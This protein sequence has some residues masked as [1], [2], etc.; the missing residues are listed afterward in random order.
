MAADAFATKTADVY[1][2]FIE[3]LNRQDLDA[4]ARQ[5]PTTCRLFLVRGRFPS[6]E[7]IDQAKDHVQRV[8]D[9]GPS[10]SMISKSCRW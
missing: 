8:W 1:R 2:A 3:A 9:A 5:Q 7:V 4:T 10:L 6:V